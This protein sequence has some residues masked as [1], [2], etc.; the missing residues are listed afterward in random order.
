MKKNFRFAFIILLLLAIGAVFLVINN[1]KGTMR[2]ESNEFAVSDTSSVTKIFLADKMNN[3]VKLE[4]VGLGD[5]KLNNS[6]SASSEM[7]NGMLKTLLLVDIKRPVAKSARNN[8]I[9]MMASK[10][11]KVEIY[12]M[13][14]RVNIFGWIKL[15]P[16]EKR[17][18]TYFVGDATQDNMGTYMLMEGSEDPYVVYIPGFRGFVATRYSS[19]ETDWRGHGIFNSK[20]PDI[21]QV[22][23][24]YSDD[25]QNSFSIVNNDNRNFILTSLA[26]N[27]TVQDFDTIKVIQ[28]LG[29]FHKI[30]FE[31][32][33]NDMPKHEFD[34]IVATPPS[35]VI[36]LDDKVGKR[37][38]MKA[39]KRK[40]DKG[41]TDMQGN[42]VEWDRDRLFA[43]VEGSR[44]LVAIQYFV[45]DPILLPLSWFKDKSR[46]SQ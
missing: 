30:N 8:I 40:A 11:V 35:V 27:I 46:A 6:L 32:F 38:V 15:F 14:Y 31:S 5:W 29:S 9:R 41:E 17:T 13:V 33:L 34:S 39:W 12:Q 7:V 22:S 21:K 16:H 23:V 43:Q 37:F 26:D 28:Y 1:R 25:P 19:Y 2:Q 20:L 45:F 24:Q 4:R 10:S 44:E 18:K 36:S 3:L 42:P